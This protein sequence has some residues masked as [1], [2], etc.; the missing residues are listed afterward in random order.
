MRY[1][2]TYNSLLRLIKMVSDGE[3]SFIIAK[4]EEYLE[5]LR[6]QL[7]KLFLKI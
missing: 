5:C 2:S 3:L 1:K 7:Y 6:R 4:K